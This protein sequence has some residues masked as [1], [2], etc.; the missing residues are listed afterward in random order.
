MDLLGQKRFAA[1][2]AR[3]HRFEHLSAL[4]MLM[5]HRSATFVDHVGIARSGE[6][7]R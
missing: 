7:G 4:A 1:F 3:H 2:R 6:R 5:Q